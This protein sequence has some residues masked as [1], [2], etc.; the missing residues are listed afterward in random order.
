VL[1]LKSG[2]SSKTVNRVL[3]IYR[4]PVTITKYGETVFDDAAYYAIWFD[5]LTV[6][7]DG[8]T[9]VTL[10][11][12]KIS[13]PRSTVDRIYTEHISAIKDKFTVLEYK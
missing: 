8:V 13:D 3:L 2:L 7:S 10:S 1:S 11:M 6:D 12:A 5:N 4:V 9:C